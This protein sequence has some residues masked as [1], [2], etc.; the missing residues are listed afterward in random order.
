MSRFRIDDERSCFPLA[1][2]IFE[3]VRL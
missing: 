2:Q 3:A 1:F